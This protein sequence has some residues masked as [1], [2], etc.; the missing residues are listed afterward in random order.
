MSFED[1]I[2]SVIVGHFDIVQSSE[3]L[4]GSLCLDGLLRWGR[5]LQVQESE[6][7]ELVNKHGSVL[8]PLNREESGDLRD[9]S[10]RW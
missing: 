4:E 10:G 3:W 2:V 6:A 8:V 5:L 9:P 7:C 1:A